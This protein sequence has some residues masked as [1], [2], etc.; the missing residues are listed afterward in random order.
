[1]KEQKK[2]HK[3]YTRAEKLKY[4]AA[5]VAMFE[6]MLAKAKERL[7]YISSD[8]YQEWDGALQEE[9]EKKAAE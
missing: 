3:K 1:M 4:Y 8:E 5:R 6:Y 7:D 2:E 9:L